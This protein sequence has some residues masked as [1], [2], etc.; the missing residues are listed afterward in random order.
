M[1]QESQLG[2]GE[3][4]EGLVKFFLTGKKPRRPV[5]EEFGGGCLTSKRGNSYFLIKR[6]HSEE[7][8]KGMKEEGGE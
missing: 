4:K 6:P 7:T 2:T 1:I 5:N 8:K 3:K